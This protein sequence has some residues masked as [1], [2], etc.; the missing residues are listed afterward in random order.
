MIGRGLQA[1]CFFQPEPGGGIAGHH[2]VAPN[3][4]AHRAYAHTIGLAVALEL[5]GEESPVEVLQPLFHGLAIK[6]RGKGTTGQGIDLRGGEA[7]ADHV[8]QEEIVEGI[9][10]NQVFGLLRNLT[11]SVRGQQ[12]RADGGVQNVQ[13]DRLRIGKGSILR[14]GLDDPPDQCLGHAAVDAVHAHVVAV[15]GA[16]A[17]CQLTQIAGADD[18]TAH[19]TG[20][21]HEDLGALPSLGVFISAVVFRNIVADVLEMQ[22]NGVLDGD[23]LSADAQLAHQ[24][25]GVLIGTVG[26]A[27]AGHGHA[28][29]ITGGAAK[30]T[31]GLHG[32]QQ[33]Q[34]GVQSTGNADDRVG[35]QQ[36]K[37]LFQS[38]Y[39]HGEDLPAALLTACLIR[40]NEGQL[41]YRVELAVAAKL[42]AKGNLAAGKA[43]SGGGNTEGAVLQALEAD[44]TQVAV[45]EDHVVA[46]QGLFIFRQHAAVFSDDAVAGVDHIRG[47]F[48]AAGGAVGIHALAGSGLTGNSGAP[49]VALAGGCVGGGKIQNHIGATEGQKSRWRDWGVEIL[50]DFHTQDASVTQL[51]QQVGAQGDRAEA[52][53]GGKILRCV[54]AGNK[55]PGLLAGKI[56]FGNEAVDPAAPNDCGAVEKT[57]VLPNG[58]TQN[59]GKFRESV[60]TFH[61]FGKSFLYAVPQGVLQKQIAAGIARQCK[62][63]EKDN[64]GTLG[65]GLCHVGADVL[66]VFGHI[67]YPNRGY[68]GSNSNKIQ[69]GNP[70]KHSLMHIS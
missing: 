56:G 27:E 57:S 32:Y 7:P 35:I 51:H 50:A 63:R 55:P 17:Q 54:I 48:G 53:K 30:L 43:V 70:S 25:P 4:K 26:S 21:V 46:V 14:N 47:G 15:I 28:V 33:C 12:L 8:V 23:L 44:A 37:T 9:G 18:N 65:I 49:L 1:F 36:G 64:I 40:G 6:V 45:L 5:L 2:P 41:A 20:V 61:D 13:Q 38:R 11:L 58:K 66:G 39:L 29:D 16:P 42:R 22:G 52:G 69:H 10:A 3:A 62:L 19:H 59:H 60:G 34:G 24:L 67:T 68:S 31:H